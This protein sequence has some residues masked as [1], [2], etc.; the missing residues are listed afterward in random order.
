ML[1]FLTGPEDF[2]AHKKTEELRKKFFKKYP[3]AV[4]GKYDL[5][6]PEDLPKAWE[7]LSQGGGLFCSASFIVVHNILAL[8]KNEANRMLALFEKRVRREREIVVVVRQKELKDKKHLAYMYL[9]KY[10]TVE[11]YKRLEGLKLRVWVDNEVKELTSGNVSLAA[12]AI[13]RLTAFYQND[14]WRLYRELEKVLTYKEEGI[15]QQQDI[16]ILCQGHFQTKIFD[17]IDAIV[18]RQKALAY[19]LLY[20]LIDQGQSEIGIFAM[21]MYQFRN[22]AKISDAQKHGITQPEILAKKLQLHPFV[23]KK[24]I[25]QMRN[26]PMERLKKIYELACLLD[27]QIKLGQKDAQD[28][29]VYFIAKI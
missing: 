27:G 14:M 19:K 1:Y 12:G 26:F 5:A 20:Q 24:S 9:N 22:L 6:E 29:L 10:A 23:V 25:V 21:V 3:D 17:L 15:L 13:D 11:E 8:K 28:A 2:L 4:S 7:R 18:I 16:D